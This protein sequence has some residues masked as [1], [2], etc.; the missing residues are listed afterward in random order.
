MKFDIIG[1][2]AGANISINKISEKGGIELYELKA[3]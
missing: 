1:A 3:I 2:S